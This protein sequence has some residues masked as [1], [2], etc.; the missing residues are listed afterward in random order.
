M[1]ATEQDD[2]LKDLMNNSQ[3]MNMQLN[4]M[5][6]INRGSSEAPLQ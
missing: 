3:F 6:Q 2:L 4:L 5:G 1:K